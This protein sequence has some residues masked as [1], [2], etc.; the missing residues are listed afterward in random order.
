MRP[1]YIYMLSPISPKYAISEFKIF[2]RHV[3]L[4]YKYGNQKFL[5]KRYYCVTARHNKKRVREY[6]QN[7]L[8]EDK[9]VDQMSIKNLFIHSQEKQ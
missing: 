5:A 6:I 7:Q 2:D 4:K 8:V 1:D 3:N 9:L